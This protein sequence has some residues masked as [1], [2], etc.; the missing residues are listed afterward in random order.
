MRELL[1]W[2]DPSSDIRLMIANV[3]KNS[4][5]S[6]ETYRKNIIPYHLYYVRRDITNKEV[7]HQILSYYT[8]ILG[9]F[10]SDEFQAKFIEVP[11]E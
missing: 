6:T 3:V 11:E 9:K 8:R 5:Y 1:E 7:Y 4:Y 10:T 2:E